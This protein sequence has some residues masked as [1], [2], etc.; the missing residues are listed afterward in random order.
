MEEGEK[1]NIKKLFT[2]HSMEK[3]NIKDF[4][5]LHSP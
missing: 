5:M 4:T 2:R 1:E 3:L